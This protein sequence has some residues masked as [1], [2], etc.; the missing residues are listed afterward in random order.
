MGYNWGF[1][2]ADPFSTLKHL[3]LQSP[4]NLYTPCML[5]WFLNFL[6]SNDFLFKQS[7]IL[8]NTMATLFELS[9]DFSWHTGLL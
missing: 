1:V 4:G 3:L 7:M 2:I 5:Y 6:A 9:N 8:V